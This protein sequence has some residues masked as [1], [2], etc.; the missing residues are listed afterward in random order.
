MRN[1][2]DRSVL[3]SHDYGDSKSVLYRGV[4]DTDVL[5]NP[6]RK[7]PKQNDI[8]GI[9]YFNMNGAKTDYTEPAEVNQLKIALTKSQKESAIRECI[10]K[11]RVMNLPSDE[12]MRKVENL[13]EDAKNGATE[14][15]YLV[16]TD[17][18]TSSLI[19]SEEH[20]SISFV[21]G[22]REFSD[23]GRTAAFDIHTHPIIIKKDEDGIEKEFV[24][25]AFPSDDDKADSKR[26]EELGLTSQPNWVLGFFKY[27]SREENIFDKRIN[28]YTSDW[29][30]IGEKDP[31]TNRKGAE[32][33]TKSKQGISFSDFKAAIKKIKK[34]PLLLIF[35]LFYINSYSFSQMSIDTDLDIYCRFKEVLDKKDTVKLV[36]LPF[37]LK[38]DDCY[39]GC[40]NTAVCMDQYVKK[41]KNTLIY[42]TVRIPKDSMITID[43]TCDQNITVDKNFKMPDKKWFRYTGYSIELPLKKLKKGKLKA[44]EDGQII[45]IFNERIREGD[46]DGYNREEHSDPSN[47]EMAKYNLTFD[48]FLQEMLKFEDSIELSASQQLS[49]I[50]NKYINFYEDEYNN[51]HYL[52]L[53]DSVEKGRLWGYRITGNLVIFLEHIDPKQMKDF[54]RIAESLKEISPEEF[55]PHELPKYIKYNDLYNRKS[56]SLKRR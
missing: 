28:F 50:I 2:L 51:T 29:A 35:L 22:Y 40:S 41:N 16:A 19:K 1:I 54:I 24:G 39:Y 31:Y 33:Y 18:T 23:D 44:Y 15:G 30:Y 34:Y 10:E 13:Y 53:R 17:G 6:F 4:L 48:E 32:T 5:N 27:V 55:N 9:H 42:R 26:Q 49:E 56:H 38:C 7:K 14:Q 43:N 47:V 45:R 21:K 20:S 12:L 46:Y 37:I 8:I 36:Y 25:Y 11:K 3:D 52:L